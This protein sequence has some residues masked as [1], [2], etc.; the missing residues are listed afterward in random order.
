M[1]HWVNGDDE[2]GRRRSDS[3]ESRESRSNS[4]SSNSPQPSSS[5]SRS[6]NTRPGTSHSRSRSKRHRDRR[7]RKTR[8]IVAWSVLGV[9]LLLVA[10]VAWVGIR[11]WMAAEALQ[12]AVPLASKIQREFASGQIDQA[13]TTA[14]QLVDRAREAQQLTGDPVWRLAEFVPF[15]GPNLA[16][17]RQAASITDSVASG[18]VFPLVSNVS[19]IGVDSFRPVNGSIDLAPL[20]SARPT[21]AA[22]RS[23]LT[24]A[25][26][27]ARGISTDGTISQVSDAVVQLQ[28]SVYEANGLIQGVDRAVTLVPQMLGVD[29][30]RKY[31]LLFQ[32]P[33]E[34]RAGGGITSS[35][36]QIDTQD[37]SV[38]MTQQA[39]GSDF[40]FDA[41]VMPLP[42]ETE[43]IYS[44]KA[45]RFMQ[46]TT[47]VPQF[48]LSG[49][50]ASTMWA[51]R[52]GT[53]V[54]GAIS[55]DPIG[56]SYLLDATGPIALQSIDFELTA[57]NA[58]QFL[59]HDIY[60]QVAE[61]SVQDAIFAEAANAV[62]NRIAGGD[63]EP[64]KLLDSLVKAG[65][66]GRL[67]IWSAHAEDQSVLA[68]TSLAGGLPQSTSTATGLG[69]YFNDATAAKMSYY[70]DSAVDVAVSSCRADGRPSYRIAVTL[71]NTAP[72]D[73]GATLPR[74]VTGGGAAG[75]TPGNV[76]TIVY[77]YGPTSSDADEPVLITQIDAGKVDAGA[78]SALDQGHQVA[79]FPVDLA[80]GESRTVSV[81][82]VGQSGSPA[83]VST[84]ITPTVAP[85]VY[86]T[87]INRGFSGC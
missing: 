52:F 4:R 56:L 5:R 33:A 53:Q 39:V 55:F 59:L 73:A 74:Y 9:A 54:D 16:A 49:Q 41:P 80:P 10:G 66:E 76:S 64:A 70:L 3:S 48:E 86:S 24:Q 40:R 77:I 15:A 51:D 28:S 18:A 78:F 68:D 6:S 23:V 22:A 11:G 63:L 87:E 38:T 81:E 29:G 71:T 62:F 7:R 82:Y 65:G 44:N 45:T 35:L 42:P 75:V 20:V 17:V 26:T 60:L 30:P 2:E 37:G 31:L 27:D 46:N 84:L 83:G 43:A 21:V 67:K 58:V 34:L 13:K 14:G 72:S 36:A 25:A 12:A 79:G 19:E 57:D 1:R 47:L 61:P 50:I 85:T 69:V 8:R 32:N